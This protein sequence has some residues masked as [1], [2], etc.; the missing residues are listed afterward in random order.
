MR[1]REEG[2]KEEEE[3]RRDSGGNLGWEDKGNSL[4]SSHANG[5]IIQ[6]GR[7]KWEGATALCCCCFAGTVG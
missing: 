5:Y 2:R 7:P 6:L 1:K 4:V 3:V